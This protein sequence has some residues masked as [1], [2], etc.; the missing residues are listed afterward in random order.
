MFIHKPVRLGYDDL[1]II[2]G[3]SRLYETPQDKRYPSMT[4]VLSVRAKGYLTEWRNR[5]GDTEADRICHHGVVRGSA[6][7]TLAE[8]YLN[9]EEINLRKEMPHVRQ[10]FR[11]LQKILDTNVN[12]ILLQE[13]ALYSDILKI[14]GRV[15][16]VAYY[17]NVLSIIDFKT[18]KTHKTIEEILDYLIQVSG[19][20]AM[21]YERT[22]IPIKQG[23]IIMVVDYSPIPLVF[24]FDTYTHIPELLKTIKDYYNFMQNVCHTHS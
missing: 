17:D 12:T 21:F 16:L 1:R 22:G 11:T 3:E 19:Y 18:S 20:A 6:L 13:G 23:V 15:D 8:K 14:A 7:H 10:S 9:N 24:K 5:V 2:D 4:T